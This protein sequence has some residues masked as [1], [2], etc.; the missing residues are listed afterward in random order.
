MGYKWHHLTFK[1]GSWRFIMKNWHHPMTRARL[2]QEDRASY[3]RFLSTV[4][5]LAL[6][7]YLFLSTVMLLAL[8]ALERERSRK[9]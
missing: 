3:N 2:S 9:K 7:A 4:M 6:E 8:E 1:G 5:L